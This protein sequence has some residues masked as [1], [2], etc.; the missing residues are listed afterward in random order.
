MCMTFAFSEMFKN[1]K[2]QFGGT[3]LVVNNAGI[4]SEKYW[5]KMIDV[6][7]VREFCFSFST[8]S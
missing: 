2:S 8:C 1:T 7:L 3:D 4:A 5:G 6:N